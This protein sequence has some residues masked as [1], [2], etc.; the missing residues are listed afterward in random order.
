MCD[1]I[2]LFNNAKFIIQ[3]I[4][5]GCDNLYFCNKDCLK[6]IFCSQNTYVWSSYYNH[7]LKN[8]KIINCGI[9]DTNSILYNKNSINKENDPYIIDINLFTKELDNIL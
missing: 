2:S 9:V 8:I 6:I 4:G 5:A 3:E 7:V 1:K